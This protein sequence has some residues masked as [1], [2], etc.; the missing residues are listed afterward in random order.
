MTNNEFI[1]DYDIEML[2]REISATV[3][4]VRQL[5]SEIKKFYKAEKIT[6]IEYHDIDDC[7][8][9]IRDDLYKK[10]ELIKNIF[11][12]LK[13]FRKRRPDYIEL[14]SRQKRSVI[15]GLTE[16]LARKANNL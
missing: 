3:K 13:D 8:G 9:H 15:S 12:S 16:V 11:V 6:T 7:I 5:Q 2:G 10:V 1:G 4:I 14:E